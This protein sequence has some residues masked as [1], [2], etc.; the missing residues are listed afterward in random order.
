[1]LSDFN[2]KD[3]NFFQLGL[4]AMD[5]RGRDMEA[6]ARARDAWIGL[7]SN[8]DFISP[9]DPMETIKKLK[10]YRA[11]IQDYADPVTADNATYEMFRVFIEF[12]RNRAL[13]LQA[14]PGATT[15]VRLFCRSRLERYENH[16][17]FKRIIPHWKEISEKHIEKFPHSVAEAL[18]Y[19][20]RYDGSEGNA[21]D[22]REI[23]RLI[24]TAQNDGLF[25]ATY[26]NKLQR[27]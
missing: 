25:N 15:L 24:V 1:M 7:L 18:S 21:F 8:V 14:I 22:E 13:N 5:R 27:I 3:A 20:V 12:N 4:I 26:A 11:A 17:L 19:S 16:A 9:N 6:M 10:E 23:E 2:W